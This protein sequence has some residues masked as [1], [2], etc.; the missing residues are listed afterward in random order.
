MWEI[1]IYG[2]VLQF[3]HKNNSLQMQTAST[4]SDLGLTVNTWHHAAVVIDR[5][6][7]IETGVPTTQLST[8]IY[9]DGLEVPII[10]S[11]LNNLNMD[12][13][14]DPYTPAPLWI[15]AGEREFDGLLDDVRFF[16]RDLT[17]LEVSIL[18]QPDKTIPAALLPIPRS[19]NVLIATDLTWEPATGAAAQSLYFGTDPNNLPL[20]TSGDGSL[21][22]AT[23]AEIGGPLA[24]NTT[25]YWYVET[26]GSNGPLWSFTTETG[27]AINPSPSD[28]EED[29]DT[30]GITLSW[31]TP[32]AA[33][34]AVYLSKD[35][36]L[37]ESNSVSVR[38]ANGITD[39]NVIL[40]LNDANSRGSTY[41]L[42]CKQ[43]LCVGRN[44]TGRYME[45]PN[46]A[47]RTCFQ[48]LRYRHNLF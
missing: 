35:I 6:N 15:G 27:K 3:Y 19:S 17:A 11:S 39:Y 29:I 33:T 24:F 18:N 1:R 22:E 36:T 23:S 9:I 21:N 32:T 7:S 31:N 20:I 13:D 42:A 38:I 4:L 2:G 10:V 26:D 40:G 5:T 25:Y 28:G 46:Q 16:S 37:V 45:L 30:N 43:H 48:H 47:V 8:K 44:D 12:V 14:T 34:Y 41:L